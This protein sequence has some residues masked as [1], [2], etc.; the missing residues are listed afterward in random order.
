MRILHVVPSYY[1]AVRYGG[2]IYS[3]HALAAALSRRGNEIHVYTTNV[4]GPNNSLVPL[5]EAVNRDGVQV[6]YYETKVGRRLYRSPDMARALRL[7]IK[8]FDL[9]HIHS[10]F[11][12][13]TL[14]AARTARESSLPYII[15]PRGM[16]VRNL[17]R[18]KNSVVKW[19]WITLF[20]RQNINQAAAIHVTSELE[21][22]EL[23]GLGFNARKIA[24]VPNGVDIP[25]RGVGIPC[26]ENMK[27]PFI[28]FLGRVNW[29]KGLDRLIPAMANLPAVQLVVAGNDEEGYVPVLRKLAQRHG[30]V[31]RVQFLGPVD[32]SRKWQL[33][34]NA[35]MLVL[36][37]YSESF[38]NVVLEAMGVG[39]P[40][41]V[42]PEV[43]LAGVV[44]QANAG[45]VVEGIPEKLGMAIRGLLQDQDACHRMG[46]AGRKKTASEFSWAA[47]AK[48]MEQVYEECISEDQ[49]RA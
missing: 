38:G 30:V 37:S 2:P 27:R 6:W 11:L 44:K 43:G 22:A 32:A 46:E 36:P 42:T 18:N 35:R 15:A 24:L 34:R 31:E 8:S 21:A 20:E 28:L 3:V 7:N 9:V 33:L 12:W 5:G 23:K 14:A 4:D 29:E 16:L 19:A 1:P 49:H 17:I 47:I 48:K 39:C 41:V 40:V 26:G 25:P 10:V 13:P 45:V